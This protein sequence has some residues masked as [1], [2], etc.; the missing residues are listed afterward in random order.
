[1]RP[2]GSGLLCVRTLA[3]ERTDPWGGDP[4]GGNFL[5]AQHNTYPGVRLPCAGGCTPQAKT[6]LVAWQAP[7]KPA[8]S[9]VTHTTV[10]VVTGEIPVRFMGCIPLNGRHDTFDRKYGDP[11]VCLRRLMPGSRGSPVL[12]SAATGAATAIEWPRLAGKT[13]KP[14]WCRPDSRWGTLP[15]EVAARLAT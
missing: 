4:A 8:R 10:R 15:F 13:G 14:A 3:S 2:A 1:M 11:A 6:A 12:S 5:T 7:C 9:P